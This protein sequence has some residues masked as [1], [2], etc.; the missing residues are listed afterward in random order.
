MRFP[1]DLLA[2]KDIG[3]KCGLGLVIQFNTHK[4]YFLVVWMSCLGSMSNPIVNLLV[5]KK[6]STLQNIL[7]STNI[8]YEMVPSYS[9]VK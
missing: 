4:N 3:C 5:S 1:C 7:Q 8:T 2:T 6:I 9:V